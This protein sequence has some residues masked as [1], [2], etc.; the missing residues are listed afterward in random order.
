MYIQDVHILAY[1]TIAVLGGII[2][3]FLGWCNKRLSEEKRVF[4]KEYF[5]KSKGKLNYVLIIIMALIYV[6]LLYRFGLEFNIAKDLK[7]I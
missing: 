1:A 4:T 7:L 2:G 6:V 3:Q 5:T